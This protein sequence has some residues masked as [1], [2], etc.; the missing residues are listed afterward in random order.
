LLARRDVAVKLGCKIYGRILSFA[1]AGVPPEVM[2]I[3]PAFAIPA[4][5]KKCG[6][7]IADIDIFEINEAFASQASYCVKA[8]GVP[9]EKLNP[10]GGAIAMGH[11]LG[12]TGARMIVTL[13]HELE[14]TN[15][16]T[17]LVSMCIGTGMGACGVFERE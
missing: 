5:L 10:R 3:G 13:F 12:M 15:K 9:K 6:F 1:V 8:L 11:P 16:K 17:G 2:G 14:R 7:G 4:A